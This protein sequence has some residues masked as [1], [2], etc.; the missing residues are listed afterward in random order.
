MISDHNALMV[1]LPICYTTRLISPCKQK[2]VLKN[3]ESLSIK[4]YMLEVL[5]KTLL[6][7]LHM[8]Q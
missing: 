5:L 3:L 2:Q 7:K 8:K 6:G 4:Q 1:M